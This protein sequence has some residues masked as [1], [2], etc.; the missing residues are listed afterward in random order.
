MVTSMD[1]V[2]REGFRRRPGPCSACSVGGRSWPWCWWPVLKSPYKAGP[3]APVL[4]SRHVNHNRPWTDQDDLA[5][6]DRLP[7]EIGPNEA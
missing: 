2:L 3:V 1:V 6:G 4:R 5:D 7:P